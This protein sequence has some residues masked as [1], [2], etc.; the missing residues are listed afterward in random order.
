MFTANSLTDDLKTILFNRRRM[1]EL[2][3]TNPTQDFTRAEAEQLLYQLPNK[4][5][6]AIWMLTTHLIYDLRDLLPKFMV[7]DILNVWFGKE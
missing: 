2:K 1:A 7:D 4:E 5:L 6:Y 3:L